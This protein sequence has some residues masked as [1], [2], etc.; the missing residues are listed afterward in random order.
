MKVSPESGAPGAY[1]RIPSGQAAGNSQPRVRDKVEAQRGSALPEAA[2]LLSQLMSEGFSL[3]SRR[4]T[5]LCHQR[6]LPVPSGGRPHSAPPPPLRPD[7]P[8]LH[9]LLPGGEGPGPATGGQSRGSSRRKVP[10]AL[11]CVGPSAS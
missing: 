1:S 8:W 3:R 7:K 6:R 9:Q 4:Q 11:S 10:L 5:F 2:P